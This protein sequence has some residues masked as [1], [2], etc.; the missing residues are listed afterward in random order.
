MHINEKKFFINNQFINANIN[1]INHQRYELPY[2]SKEEKLKLDLHEEEN[3]KIIRNVME[4]DL[5]R[6]IDQKYFTNQKGSKEFADKLKKFEEEI[7]VEE[8]KFEKFK[9]K[10]FK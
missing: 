4:D 7:L 10:L 6:K 3:N 9:K 8:D 5:I 1:K 2:S